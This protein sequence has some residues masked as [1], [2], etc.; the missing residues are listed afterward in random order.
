MKA[1]KIFHGGLLMTGVSFLV[2]GVWASMSLEAGDWLWRLSMPFSG[3]SLLLSLLADIGKN[4]EGPALPEIAVV[5][6]L[7]PVGLVVGAVFSYHTSPTSPVA[8][9]AIIGMLLTLGVL[10]HVFEHFARFPPQRR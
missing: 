10:A 3:M 8:W 7:V 9:T 5:A 4:E 6:G 1:E 2:G